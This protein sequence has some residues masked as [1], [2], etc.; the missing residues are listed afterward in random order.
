MALLLLVGLLV[1]LLLAAVV[2]AVVLLTSARPD[3]TLTSEVASA[4]RHAVGVSALSV[5]VTVLA[6]AALVGGI[7]R[8]TPAHPD[9]ARVAIALLPLAATVAAML[10]LLSGELTW[11]RP[12]GSVRS[13]VLHDRS[14]R[15]FLAGRWPRA[16]ALSVTAL[17]LVLLGGGLLGADDGRSLEHSTRYVSHRAT[18]FPGWTYTVPQLV[19]LLVAVLVA[20]LVVRT[21]ARRSAVVTADLDTDTVLRRASVGRAVR[22]LVAG[23]LCTLG[24]DLLTGGSSMQSVFTGTV[25]S[26]VGVGM[27]YLGMALVVVGA[28]SLLV[29][30]P[31]LSSRSPAQA[32][33]AARTA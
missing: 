20:A 19:L 13:A 15:T 3:G 29:P 31:R 7:V 12:T 4:R 1:P 24:P 33:P 28:A 22:V 18:P 32:A 17:L 25:W 30:V 21:A 9:L 8:V 16:G 10:V 14:V 6:V 11:P 5:V 2:V 26:P 23:C 27:V